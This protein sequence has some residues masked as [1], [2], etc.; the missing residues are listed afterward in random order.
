MRIGN[1]AGVNV[2]ELCRDGAGLSTREVVALL[3]EIC[4]NPGPAFPLTPDDLWIADNG[5]LLTTQPEQSATPTDPFTAV[6]NLLEM[7]LSSDERDPERTVSP[8][9]LGLPARLRA[10]SGRVGPK[11]RQD[12]ALIIS[13]HLAADAREIIQQLKRRGDREAETAAVPVAVEAEAT[14]PTVLTEPHRSPARGEKVAGA[15]TAVHVPGPSPVEEDFDLYVDQV[16]APWKSA[17]P[18]P[19]PAFSAVRRPPRR[20]VP[21]LAAGALFLVIVGAFY[22]SDLNREVDQII[23]TELR[24]APGAAAGGPSVAPPTAIDSAGAAVE[25]DPSAFARVTEAGPAQPLQLSVAGGAFSPAFAANGQELFFH[26]GHSAT[27][28]L[29]VASLDDRGQVSRVRT[30]LDD[31]A[32]SYHPRVS[33]D[34]R[35]LAFDSD[36]DGERGVYI[37][38]RDGSRPQRVSGSGYGA[39]PSWSPDMKRLAFVRGETGRAQVWNLWLRDLSSGAMQRHTSFRSGQVW[40]ASWFPD[41]RSLC[42]SHETQLVISHLDGRQDIV[43]DTPRPGRLVRTPAV[44]P[45]GRRV[46][47]QVFKDGVWLLDVQTR[48]MLRIL[49]DP[50]AEEFSWAPD[51]VR[52]AYHS[53]H[54]GTWRIWVAVVGD[55]TAVPF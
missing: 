13:W 17:R 20:M 42:Y 29:L 41:G 6:A 31:A 10:A 52:I 3:Y 55:R 16:Q 14:S 32:K 39:V 26:A 12:L 18:A 28:R 1:L 21:A 35:L 9:L 54:G 24:E 5:E 30:L 51:G 53:R 23:A 25:E 2:G 11:A 44:S 22:W 49:D 45:D 36:R 33:P 27:G 48:Q 37:S 19:S 47:F 40:G 4:S 7:M 46:A 38:E 15:P 34:G 50:T 8:S 43:I